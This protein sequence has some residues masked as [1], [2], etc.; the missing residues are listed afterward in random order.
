MAT[1]R[2]YSLASDLDIYFF[3]EGTHMRIYDFLGAHYV[4][5][6]DVDGTLFAVWAPNAE[7]VYV[8]GDFNGWDKF[9]LKMF[10]RLDSS[11]IWEG[12]VDGDLRGQ[13]YKYIIKTKDNRILEK[14]DP[15]AFRTEIPSGSSGNAALV[16][17]VDFKWTDDDYMKNVRPTVN[18]LNRP[19]SIYELHLGSWRRTLENTCIPYKDITK[20]LPQ[21][22][23]EQGFTHVEI[24]P[25]MEHPFYGS[26][27][28]QTSGYF[29]P[30]TRYGLPEDFAE[31]VNALHNAGIA[32]I[33]DWVPAHFPMD[34]W[35]LYRF[36]GTAL[37]E[38]E[39][40][41]KGFH[42][43]WKSAIFNFSRY[44]V[45]AF[46]ISSA[47]FWIDKYHV[48]GLRIDAVASMLYLDYSRAPGE[49]IPNQFGGHENLEAIDFL[50]HLNCAL[51][52]AN[53]GISVT[54]EE[55][56]AWPGV[57][58]P[59]YLG[60]LG[61]GYKWNMGW[62][63]DFLGYISLD[64]VYRKYHQDQMT[65]GIWYAWSENFT[66]PLSHDEVVYGK[67]SLFNKMPGDYWQ[68]CASLRLTFGFMFC[69]PGKKLIFMGGE[70]GQEREWNHEMS[71]DWHLYQDW[72]HDGINRWFR[73]INHFYKN[74]SPLWELDQTSNCFR[75]IDIND[76]DQSIAS[77]VRYDSKG[78]KIVA[79]FN[80]TPVPRY[81]YR[82][83]LPDAGYWKEVLNSDAAIYG[84]SG[85]GNCGGVYTED[86]AIHGFNQSARFTLPP[87]GCLILKKED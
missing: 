62:M 24:M 57:T 19:Q 71:L 81:D 79:I 50:H 13:N 3:K 70:F 47:N 83:G 38:H 39:D 22:L 28:Y 74:N 55:S 8:E 61:F 10:P 80:F 32:V 64:P 77:M 15:V 69:H 2:P 46:L 78:N 49:W 9:S 54:A 30:T 72:G 34:S 87:L 35:G 67:C 21:Y 42:P 84:G 43:D 29:A 44:E 12:L 41:R 6:K 16:Q 76:R 52:G 27:G 14:F 25:V 11:G 65:F 40:P 66:L 48:D 7:E 36:D 60:G 82:V 1:I 63:H 37:Y 5:N 68:K 23:Q 58:T 45:K 18:A 53:P 31:L 17:D 33:L 26:W 85:M 75:W 20:M 73:D 86:Y 4:K 56:T 59:V 51:Y